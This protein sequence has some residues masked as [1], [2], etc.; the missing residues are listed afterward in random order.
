MSETTNIINCTMLGARGVGKTSLLASMYKELKQILLNFDKLAIASDSKTAA[1]LQDR[2]SELEN[3]ANETICSVSG[4][5]IEGTTEERWFGFE[6]ARPGSAPHTRINF[7]DF[8]G[9]WLNSDSPNLSRVEQ[10]CKQSH[11]IMLAIDTPPMFEKEGKF[12]EYVNRK[13]QIIEILKKTVNA[14]EPRLIV[15]A[16]VRCERYIKDRSE[17]KSILE[18]VKKE[19]SELIS[20]FRTMDNV[21][22]GII[23]VQ[24]VGCLH[25]HSME[26]ENEKLA[27]IRFRKSRPDAKY[28]PVNCEQPLVF[29]LGF[30]L[31]QM[32][33]GGGIWGKL[34]TWVGLNAEEITALKKLSRK[35]KDGQ[36]TIELL[37]GH[38]L[39]E[40]S[41]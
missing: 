30:C 15:L 8:P 7:C 25:F 18:T 28:S 39:L 21:S 35:R 4:D 38:N 5:K 11:A 14:K 20:H 6:M 1:Q 17:K 37:Q 36:D 40:V 29:L 2:I 16:P 24:T 27:R 19:Y 31:H 22:L 33:Y 9:G 23:P 34:K 13:T 26:F 32:L 12:H 3:L 41:E 10:L